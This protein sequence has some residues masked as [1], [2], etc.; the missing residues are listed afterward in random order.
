MTVSG[1][2][3]AMLDD[4]KARFSW[5]TNLG[6][7]PKRAADRECRVLRIYVLI[8]RVVECRE[9]SRMILVES[10]EGAEEQGA[11]VWP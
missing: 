7:S 8:R 3:G 4:N 10:L 6:L 5:P 1:I 11:S 9:L 2:T